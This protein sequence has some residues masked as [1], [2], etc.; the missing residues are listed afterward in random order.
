MLVPV[1]DIR[2]Q[3]TDVR[4]LQELTDGRQKAWTVAEHMR[5]AGYSREEAN[6]HAIAAVL[7]EIEIG[8]R[9]ER[10]EKTPG[11][12]ATSGNGPEGV[13]AY[14]AALRENQ[15]RP[16]TAYQWRVMAACPDD[17][18]RAFFARTMDA[19]GYIYAKPIYALGKKARAATSERPSDAESPTGQ[20]DD[21]QSLV[22]TGQ[23]FGTI[24]ADPPWF[25]GNQGTRA[26]TSNHYGGMTVDQIAALPVAALAA[27]KAHLHLWTTNA[28]LFDARRVVEA[29][30]FEYKSCFVWVKPQMGIGNYWRVSHEFMLLGVRGGLTFP[31]DAPMSWLEA[32][33]GRHSA[34]PERVRQLVE[35]MSPGPRLEL[36]A[37]LEAEG[38][39]VW[40][41]GVETTLFSKTAK[42]AVA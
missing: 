7:H 33:R 40:G 14:K 31:N 24:Y 13:T 35:K 9:L 38:W 28:F 19:G 11:T 25:Y 15:I 1:D 10:I 39:Q 5:K 32:P 41:N 18:L 3:L 27:N 12:R 16:R 17:E 36:F 8:R 4:S 30:G 2:R 34:K 42:E 37:R 6:K 22:D 26:A 20:I 23:T 29:W 21:L